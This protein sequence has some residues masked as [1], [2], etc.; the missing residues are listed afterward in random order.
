MCKCDAS[1]SSIAFDFFSLTSMLGG[2]V[3]ERHNELRNRVTDLAGKALTPSHV[4]NDP[5]IS[6]GRAVKRTKA[7]P[8]GASGTKDHTRA[9]PLEVMKQKV[10]LLIRDLW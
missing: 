6:S 1:V 10:D 9:P 4:R 7:T 8:A 3:T 2:L 5:L